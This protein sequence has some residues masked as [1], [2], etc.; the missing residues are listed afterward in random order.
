MDS[1]SANNQLIFHYWIDFGTESIDYSIG[2]AQIYAAFPHVKTIVS[3]SKIKK[4][5]ILPQ[6]VHL[7]LFKDE[8]PRNTIHICHLSFMS[9]QPK[10]FIIA[11]YK[12]QYFLGPD[13]GMFYMAFEKD[14][15]Q[16]FILPVDKF[17]YNALREVYLPGI[18]MLIQSNFELETA[19][20]PKE[21]LMKMNTIQPTI[22][23]NIMRLT[24]LY[25][26]SYGN[27]YFNL[28]R[29]GFEAFTQEK[30]FEFKSHSFRINTISNDYDDVPE[31][32]ILALFS[33]GNLL[34]IAGNAGNASEKLAIKEDSMILLE[35]SR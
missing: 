10:R 24:A 18:E 16:F 2:Q 35:A 9:N 25:V 28:D 31:G 29:E 30:P 27:V 3:P 12:E 26:D 19:F 14:N 6:S 11:K 4:G 17:K 8:F 33:Y 13:N 20:K 32:E 7:K 15:V 23:N 34:Q 22:S 21:T 5:H 1:L